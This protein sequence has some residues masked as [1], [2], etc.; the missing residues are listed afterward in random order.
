MWGS[1]T[2]PPSTRKKG[3]RHTDNFWREFQGAGKFRECRFTILKLVRGDACSSKVASCLLP[4][5][6]QMFTM[7][8]LFR[9][10]VACSFGM[11]RSLLSAGCAP[12]KLAELRSDC[13]IQHPAFFR[14]PFPAA[15]EKSFA[16]AKGEHRTNLQGKASRAEENTVGNAKATKPWTKRTTCRGQV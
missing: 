2:S 16:A 15:S 3:G 10:R 7:Q 14:G 11:F 8:T 9:K 1:L 6:C 13:C 5:P 4:N 12:D